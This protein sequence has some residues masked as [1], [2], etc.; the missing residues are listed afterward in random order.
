[1]GVAALATL[2]GYILYSVRVCA[3]ARDARRIGA[4]AEGRGGKLA[5]T[6][7]DTYAALKAIGFARTVEEVDR[8]MAEA[9]AS[10]LSEDQPLYL[11][12]AAEMRREQLRYES[13]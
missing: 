3:A 4:H 11:A 12:E 1:V 13:R 7:Y 9:R 8:A 5:V 2:E 10:T 6:P